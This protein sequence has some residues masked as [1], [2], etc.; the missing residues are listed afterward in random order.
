MFFSFFN[1]LLIIL[2]FFLVNENA[3]DDMANEE[4][5]EL[6][7]ALNQSLVANLPTAVEEEPQLDEF[8]SV[9]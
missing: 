7:A 6:V 2:F 3:T 9:S 4:Y 1:L 8:P 5:N